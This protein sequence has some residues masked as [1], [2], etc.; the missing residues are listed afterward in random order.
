MR[1][2]KVR[3]EVERRVKGGRGKDRGKKKG[4]GMW[5][6]DYDRL[7]CHR[8]TDKRNDVTTSARGQRGE[9]V[10]RNGLACVTSRQECD[11]RVQWCDAQHTWLTLISHALHVSPSATLIY[12]F[13]FTFPY[14]FFGLI[15]LNE[16]PKFFY[17]LFEGAEVFCGPRF[18]SHFVD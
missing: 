10:F 13:F 16:L 9:V 3:K 1:K 14:V 17:Y 8:Q 4:E 2:G 6:G 5:R 7:S 11:G 12:I 15:V 18:L